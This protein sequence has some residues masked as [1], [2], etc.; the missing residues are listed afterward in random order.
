M[1]SFHLLTKIDLMASFICNILS[2]HWQ[3]R[4]FPG[5][6]TKSS[7]SSTKKRRSRLLLQLLSL[8]IIR[9]FELWVILQIL[10]FSDSPLV[11]SIYV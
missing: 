11:W 1:R 9:Y 2:G 4:I 10:F 6:Q 3:L 8:E 7:W 5:L